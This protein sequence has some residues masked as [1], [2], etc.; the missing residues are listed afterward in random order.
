VRADGFVSVREKREKPVRVR[1]AGGLRGRTAGIKTPR[2]ASGGTRPGGD[3]PIF[4]TDRGGLPMCTGIRFTGSDGSMY[5]GRNFDWTEDYG[6]AV[7]VTPRAW[8]WNAAFLGE[9]TTVHACIGVAVVAEGLPLYFDAGNE[10]GLAVAGLNFPG[11][12]AY[13]DA[14]VPGATNVAAYELPLWVASSF[15]SVDEAE[16][17]LRDVAVVGK[18]VNER[19]PVSYLHWLV[20]DRHRAIVVEHTAD[21]MH[22]F[23]NDLDVLTNQPGFGYHRENVR[24]YMTVSDAFARPVSWDGA[25]LTAWGAGV[26]MH[27][28]PGDFSSPSR[29]VR[30]AYYNSHYPEQTGEEANVVR[31]VR[32]LLGTSM[33]LGAAR[34]ADGRFETTI[35]TGGYSEASRTYYCASYEEP[36]IKAFPMTEDMMAGDR[37][38]TR[39]RL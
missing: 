19:W 29:F 31:L 1:A 27:G 21:G 24:N 11:Y 9:Q 37:L 34:V 35:Y 25:E 13:A 6:E 32:T 18:Q 20:A 26:G 23:E 8:R 7:T 4:P 15:A 39:P 14:P 2:G 16:A 28:F 22:V 5:F 33:V 30:A 3:A 12:A 38:V 36:Q 17:A 10:A